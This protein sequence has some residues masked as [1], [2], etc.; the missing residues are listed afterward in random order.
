MSSSRMTMNSSEKSWILLPVLEELLGPRRWS[1]RKRSPV[2]GGAGPRRGRLQVV[3]RHLRLGS[4]LARLE[5]RVA[6]EELLSRFPDFTCDE[7]RVERAYSGNV[8]GLAKLPL[9]IELLVSKDHGMASLACAQAEAI[10]G[11]RT[12]LVQPLSRASKCW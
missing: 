10:A 8:R 4:S 9:R 1:P 6:F 3:G 2:A 7:T 11:L 5:T 12:T